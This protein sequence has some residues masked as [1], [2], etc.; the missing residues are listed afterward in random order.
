MN[1]VLLYLTYLTVIP[2]ACIGYEMVEARKTKL[3]DIIISYPTGASR[4]IFFHGTCSHNIENQ[5]KTKIKYPKK[6]AHMLAIFIEH[7]TY[8]M[9]QPMKTLDLH[10][11]V[12]QFLISFVLNHYIACYIFCSY[13]C[14]FVCSFFLI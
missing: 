9:A 5:T 13:I 11:P 8:I 6:V 12:N 4:I 7:G 10:H 3:A 2:G 1:R 14:L